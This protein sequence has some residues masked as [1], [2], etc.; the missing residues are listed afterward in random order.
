MSNAVKNIARFIIFIFIQE[1]VLDRVPPLHQYVMPY[2][3]FIFILWLP[4]SINKIGLLFIG[5]FTGLAIDFFSGTLGLHAAPCVLIAY[6]R[7]F[8]L[9][10]LIP[11][12][13]LEQAYVEP[14]AQSMGWG[15]YIFYISILTFLHHA[16][17]VII[18]WMQVG[19]FL[20]FI[21]K[22][23][24]TSLLS[25]VLILLTELLVNRKLKY[26]TNA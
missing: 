16:Y 20:F 18:E 10:L 11:Q 14:S 17:L 25:I 23:G 9:N 15:A 2:L 4:F 13:T 12:E 7:P 5:L 3:Y 1:F 6:T 19:N 24:A 26:R 8:I 21:S 22:I